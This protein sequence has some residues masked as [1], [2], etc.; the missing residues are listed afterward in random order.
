MPIMF[1][2]E[3]NEFIWLD[4]AAVFFAIDRKML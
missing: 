2:D 4:H 3:G 1:F